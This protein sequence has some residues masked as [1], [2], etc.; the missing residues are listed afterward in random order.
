M[1]ATAF[2]KMHGL[3]NDFLVIDARA[4]PVALDDGQVRRLADRHT[5]IGFDQLVLIEP[6]TAAD[7]RLRFWNSDGSEVGACGNGSRAAAALLGGNLRIETAGGPLQASAAAGGATVDMGPPRHDWQAVPLA[8]AM[9]TAAL[10]LAWA[11]GPCELARPV[12]LSVGNPHA[13][14][15]VADADAVPLA[16]LGP[17]IEHDPAFPEGVNVGV[18]QMAGRAAMRLRVWER[19][20]GL[21]RACGTGAVAA[22]AAAQRRG[23]ADAQ[24]VV[25]MP[26]GDM[27]VERRGDGHL[28]LQGPAVVAFTGQ[29]DLE[30][31]R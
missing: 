24:V 19:G 1:A 14:F 11:D 17:R 16:V 10:P 26:G 6:G 30:A 5:G 3:G 28:L 4:V 12:A 22:V 21:T 20:A 8:F 2:T 15:F 31:F 18:A 25:T 9:D 29:V 13:V 23:L 27:V 7:V